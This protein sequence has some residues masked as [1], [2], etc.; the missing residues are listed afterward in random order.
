MASEYPCRLIPVLGQA[1][2]AGHLRG[3]KGFRAFDRDGS[4]IATLFDNFSAG[5]AALLEL[6]ITTDKETND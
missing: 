6:A 2:C 1:G 4:E 3:A 5:A